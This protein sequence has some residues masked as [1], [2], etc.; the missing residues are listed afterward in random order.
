VFIF[1]AAIGFQPVEQIDD[2]QLRRQLAVNVE[3]PIATMQAAVPLFPEE[4]GRVINTS[5]RSFSFSRA[6]PSTR[7]RKARSTR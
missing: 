4:G 7:Q 6:T 1:G 5:P 2:A 3:G